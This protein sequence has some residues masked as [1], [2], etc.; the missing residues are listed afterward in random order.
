[1]QPAILTPLRATQKQKAA[2]AAFCLVK[3]RAYRY[4]PASTLKGIKGR[5]WLSP[6]GGGHDGKAAKAAT[7]MH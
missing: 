5:P 4:L 3:R 7:F 2:A 1:M 6:Q